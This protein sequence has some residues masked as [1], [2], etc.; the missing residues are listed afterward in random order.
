VGVQSL[1]QA[2]VKALVER[3]ASCY[4]EN[5]YHC[6]THACDVTI[7]AF[8]LLTKYGGAEYLRPIDSITLVLSALMHDAGHPGKTNAF[9]KQTQSEL[10]EAYGEV[11]EHQRVQ[12]L[13][14]LVLLVLQVVLGYNHRCRALCVGRYIRADAS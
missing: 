9:E 12:C 2:C 7:S 1:P 13:L 11:G 5:T 8:A 3:V 6:F 4:Q 10:V 14:V